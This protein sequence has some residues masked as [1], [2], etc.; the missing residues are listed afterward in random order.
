MIALLMQIKDE[1][2]K[3][4]D[5]MENNSRKMVDEM[6]DN[7]RKMHEKLD[8]MNDKMEDN[9]KKMLDKMA[10]IKK[11]MKEMRDKMDDNAKKFEDLKTTVDGKLKN[12]EEVTDDLENTEI[13]DIPAVVEETLT[14]AKV[15]EAVKTESI[16]ILEFQDEHAEELPSDKVITDE[17]TIVKTEELWVADKT[18]SDKI[19]DITR[20]V[21]HEYVTMQKNAQ[22]LLESAK[23]NPEI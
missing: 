10:D 9:L 6:S 23:T 21:E 15:K 8:R 11:V 7:S 19:E 14:A 20:P 12:I 16:A 4:D 17:A 2:S 22:N 18:M 13:V 1:M 3:M 5:K